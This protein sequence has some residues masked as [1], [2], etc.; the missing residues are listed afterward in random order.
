M[1]QQDL[2]DIGYIKI[3]RVKDFHQRK[4]RCRV[5]GTYDTWAHVEVPL[6][7]KEAIEIYRTKK[8]SMGAF[9]GLSE[10]D[11]IIKMSPE[12]LSK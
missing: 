9:A 7:V 6:W 1:V 12:P 5:M 3:S 11:F 8:S 4:V 2:V 10:M